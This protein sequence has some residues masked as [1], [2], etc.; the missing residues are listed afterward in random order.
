M[1][2]SVVITVIL[3]GIVGKTEKFNGD[4]YRYL[5]QSVNPLSVHLPPHGMRIL[6]PRIV[7]ILPL[8]FRNGF[9]VVTVTAISGTLAVGYLILR[10]LGCSILAAL[11]CLSGLVFHSGIR[12]ALYHYPMADPL[13]YLLIELSILGVL[14]KSDRLFS[15]SLL[16]GVLNRESSMFL[17][18]FFHFSRWKRWWSWRAMAGTG[19][20]C[21]M[22]IIGFILT[23]FVLYS[24]SDE[25]YFTETLI[26]L[27]LLQRPEFGRFDKFYMQEIRQI[28]S[29]PEKLGVALSL[30]TLTSG[31]GILAPLSIL[32]WI[33][34]RRE[35]RML[36]FYLLCVWM[37]PFVAHQAERLVFYVFPA[38]LVLSGEATRRADELP[39][40]MR[41]IF[42]A[43]QAIMGFLRPSWMYAGVGLAILLV[44]FLWYSRKNLYEKATQIF[45]EES[46]PTNFPALLRTGC[47]YLNTTIVLLVMVNLL[48]I[49]D[50]RP[51]LLGR[52]Q[53][54]FSNLQ[55]S[56]TLV[57]GSSQPC[58]AG[59]HEIQLYQERGLNLRVLVP[60]EEGVRLAVPA[61]CSLFQ[62]QDR[63][64]IIPLTYPARESELTIGVISAPDRSGEVRLQ[65]AGGV[66]Y[67]FL[68]P[69][70][71]SLN[72]SA[73]V[74][75]Q[76]QTPRKDW[77][78]LSFTEGVYLIDLLVFERE[79]YDRF[80]RDFRIRFDEV[81]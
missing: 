9:R 26:R 54:H 29:D 58:I 4:E 25:A 43:C 32:G 51:V 23:R 44:F 27:H 80:S 18:P 67:K 30:N 72:K 78:Y 79:K 37:Q 57:I 15:C 7:T 55:K 8:D 39:P 31:F 45:P 36:I 61:L 60:K 59:N 69:Q 41:Y 75:F 70:L 53:D 48:L 71:G 20:I 35:S 24:M 62:G 50:A 6:T 81:Y 40:R 64:L 42:L 21:S 14:L 52:L 77:L 63:F 73:A 68:K 56:N 17:I 11:A 12:Q 47:S 74:P 3:A 34:G 76:F 13:S 1:G 22:G 28:L 65:S 2:V 10:T 33:W 16:L 66:T 49:Y 38:F 5:N 19:L 46:V